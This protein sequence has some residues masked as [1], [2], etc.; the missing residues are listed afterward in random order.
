[1][2]EDQ[3]N[4]I[5]TALAHQDRQIQDMSEMI[6]RQWKEIER[7]KTRL[8]QSESKLGDIEASLPARPAAERP[9]HY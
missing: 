1:M 5:E 7:L 8:E 2:N 6:G 3:L 4:R 9:P